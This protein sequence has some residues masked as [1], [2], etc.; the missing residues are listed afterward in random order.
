MKTFIY[1]AMT[2]AALSFAGCGKGGGG[3]EIAKFNGDVI[4][5]PEYLKS[6]ETLD[7]VVVQ[8]PDGRTAAL[9]VAQPLSSQALGKVIET[10][11]VF[12]AAKDE[13]VT[14]S[15]DDIEKE[16]TLRKGLNP[17][18]VDSMK[19]LGYTLDEIKTAIKKDLCDYNL[20]VKSM[21]QKTIKDAQDYVR[22]NPKQ[23]EMAPTATMRWI[24]VD[25]D[26]QKAQVDKDLHSNI[27]FG[28][29]AAKDSTI[30]SAKVDNGAM[31]SAG[32]P[33]PRPA[34]LNASLPPAL[35]KAAQA[36]KVGT[37]S[38]WFK[39]QNKWVMIYV[40]AKSPAQQ[41][42]PRPE[43]L[44]VI[45]RQLTLQDTKGQNDISKL[46]LDKL[47]VAK[48]EV[49]PQYLKKNWD[50][51]VTLL[52]QRAADLGGGTPPGA[53]PAPANIPAPTAAGGKTGGAKK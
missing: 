38:D 16:L 35:L 48:V 46:L 20:R 2:A 42:T 9:P 39:V 49:K 29:V 44:E 22:N 18:Y 3:S 27:T 25:T 13:G 43:Q 26:A 45:R 4:S 28:A 30:P 34:P 14:P 21:T 23:F 11:V 51:F 15:S 33:V 17:S 40:E 5:E 24:V 10:R 41:V 32:G 52:K 47:L 6:M 12:Q 19:S 1:I 53:A 31:N 8:L 7:K 37:N 36:T 50:N